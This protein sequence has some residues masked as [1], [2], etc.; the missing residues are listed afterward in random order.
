M[1]LIPF[2]SG[3][4]SS[5]D[6]S[7]SS[8]PGDGT[9]YDESSSSSSSDSRGLAREDDPPKSLREAW[10]SAR[11]TVRQKNDEKRI[12]KAGIKLTRVVQGEGSAKFITEIID[13][14]HIAIEI[15]RENSRSYI[16]KGTSPFYL[17]IASDGKKRSLTRSMI[18]L[19]RAGKKLIITYRRV[20]TRAIRSIIKHPENV[21]FA[22]EKIAH[23][24]LAMHLA[25]R[26]LYD[27]KFMRLIAG[28]RRNNNE[29]RIERTQYF[30]FE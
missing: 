11:R 21:L 5:D 3:A 6:E 10:N 20:V 16:R 19:Q 22:L 25:H 2:G 15:A 8:S 7:N 4:G 9:S 30:I 13:L 1:Q 29:D 24:I 28:A 17:F 14:L 26:G 27:T 12:Q 18:N 23:S